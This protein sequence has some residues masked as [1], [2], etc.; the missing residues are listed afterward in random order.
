MCRE[1]KVALR[2]TE[3]FLACLVVVVSAYLLFGHRLLTALH[4]GRALLLLDRLAGDRT[5]PLAQYLAKADER[6]VLYAVTAFVSFF[7][8]LLLALVIRRLLEYD[9]DSA[10][11]ALAGSSPARVSQVAGAFLLYALLTVAFFYP[12]LPHIDSGLIGPPE[13]N[14]QHVWDIWWAR[15]VVQGKGDLL[16]TTRVFYPEG[17]SLVYHPFSYYNLLVA[18]TLGAPLSDVAVYNSLV[19]LTFVLSGV[20]AFLLARHL[21]GDTAAALVGGFVF[22]FSPSHFA[23]SLHQIEI[24]SIQFIPFFVLFYIKVLEGGSARNVIWASLFFLLNSLCSWYYMLFGLLCMAACYAM[25]AYRNKRLLMPRLFTASLVIVAVT[26]I[27]LSPLIVRMVLPGTGHA[28]LRP[29]GHG[30]FVVDFSGFFVPHYYHWLAGTPVVA[31][32]NGSYTGFPWE[33]VGYLGVF[34]LVLTSASCLV[35]VK[36]AAPYVLA[37]LVS[38]VLALGPRPHML[39]ATLPIVLPYEL[40]RHIP[41][42]SGARVPGRMMAY[43]YLFI[44]VLVAIALSYQLREGFLRRRRWIAA[45]LVLGV[46]IDFWT[47]CREVTPVRLPRAYEA[48]RRHE[49]RVD[50][51]VLDLPGRGNVFRARYM[52]YQTLHGIPIVEGYLPR[53]PKPSLVDRLEYGDLSRQKEQLRSAHVKYVVVHKQLLTLKPGYGGE[54]DPELY[55]EEYGKFYEDGENLV[56]RVY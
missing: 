20:G 44:G 21:T 28:S 23:H 6:L 13:D 8:Y 4:G 3:V 15:Q 7:F 48:I 56:L 37:L 47:P 51:G 49:P 17:S 18:S 10:S 38:S 24:A 41:V 11:P 12:I 25:A 29:G 46:C 26:L 34:C 2:V 30:R 33:S 42:L 53:K 39:G 27:V 16:Y 31:Q 52:M 9:A 40:I 43:A 1:L 22:A 55:I 19:L 45:L 36:R 5:L 14:M 50:F 35:L 54:V 32:V